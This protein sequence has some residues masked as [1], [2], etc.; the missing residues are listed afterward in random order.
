MSTSDK[1]SVLLVEDEASL[2]ST[3]RLNLE[4]EGYALRLAT[5]GPSALQKL[6]EE[7]FDA[8]LLDIMLPEMDGLE[9]LEALRL[10]HPS[11][12]VLILSARGD[13]QDRILG[14]RKGA[15]DYLAKPFHLEELL[16]RLEKLLDKSTQTNMM[17]APEERCQFAGN[18]IDFRAQQ[19]KNFRGESFELSLKESL[20]LRLLT[21]HPGEAISRER[22]LQSVWGYQV[23]PTTRT[24]DNF[25]LSFRKYFEQDSSQPKHF[26]SVRGVGY[27][28]QPQG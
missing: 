10:R 12:P 20:L 26:L 4:L 11:L 15:D 21:A 23:Y 17:Q 3:L 13:S 28:F 2:A 14:L 24:I 1:K 19:A 9:V 27:R 16:L 7:Y 8:V 6:K 5:D 25:I 18:E 22:I